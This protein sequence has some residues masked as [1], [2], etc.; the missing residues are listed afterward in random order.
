MV[1]PLVSLVMMPAAMLSVLA[2]PFGLEQPFIV[3]MGWS[4]D[5][6]LDEAAV[7]ANWS[8][9]IDAHRCSHR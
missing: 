1:M 4:I 5:R 6:M 2:M 3:A 8:Q 9:A 7:V